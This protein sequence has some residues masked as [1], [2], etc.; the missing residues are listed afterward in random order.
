[1]QLFISL[2][3]NYILVYCLLIYL[4]INMTSNYFLYL[5]NYLYSFPIYIVLI[6]CIFI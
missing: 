6:L 1:M 3:G 2:L 5:G 4:I